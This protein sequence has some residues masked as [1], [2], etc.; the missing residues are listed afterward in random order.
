MRT[1]QPNLLPIHLPAVQI[2]EQVAGPPVVHSMRFT[3]AGGVSLGLNISIAAKPASP[4]SWSAEAEAA[5]AS[6]ADSVGDEAAGSIVC[7]K[8]FQ[9]AISV[10]DRFHNRQDILGS[11]LLIHLHTYSCRKMN[12][13]PAPGSAVDLTGVPLNCSSRCLEQVHRPTVANGTPP[14]NYSGGSQ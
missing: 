11:L 6:S 3:S 2:Q 13:G 14:N 10:L 7:G 9:L 1:A 5:E 8:F 12:S 4:Y